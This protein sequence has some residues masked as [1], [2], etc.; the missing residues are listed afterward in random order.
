[1]SFYTNV[2]QYGNSLL[3]RYV[4]DGKRLTKRVKY[5]PTLFDLVNT[6][7]KTG[8]NTLDGRAVLPHKFESIREAKDW[9]AD[10]DNQD[11]VFGNTQYPYCW[12][13]DEYPG[14]VDWDLDQMLVITIDIEVECENGFPKPEDALEPRAASTRS[15]TLSDRPQLQ[16][17]FRCQ[18]ACRQQI[19][20]IRLPLA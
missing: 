4:E 2:L 12:I 17:A 7:E 8:Y 16:I 3:V 18:K 15:D 11:I 14:R 9:I 13:A 6:R 10:R 5:Q 1:M 19:P 20:Q